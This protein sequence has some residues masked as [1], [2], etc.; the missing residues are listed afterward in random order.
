LERVIEQGADLLLTNRLAEPSDL[1]DL[2]M[3]WRVAVKQ[4]AGAS[5][6]ELIELIN[7]QTSQMLAGVTE[8]IDGQ[9]D[10]GYHEE[11]AIINRDAIIRRLAERAADTNDFVA[12]RRFIAAVSSSNEQESITAALLPKAQT[13]EQVQAIRPDEMT[14]EYSPWLKL[15]FDHADELVSGDVSAMTARAMSYAGT[16]NVEPG[17]K[18][19][20]IARV[21]STLAA[22]DEQRMRS[23]AAV[24]EPY[25]PRA[26]LYARQILPMLRA[27]GEGFDETFYLSDA[28]ILAGDPDESQRIYEDIASTGFTPIGRLT[29]FWILAQ[30]INKRQT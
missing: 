28:L 8:T 7:L 24:G 2:Q 6:D 4:H 22:Q 23:A 15:Q 21:H 14:L 30:T 12:V 27:A 11:L 19:E 16:M 17:A 3:N 29:R 20:F 26:P 25:E 9:Q 1:I 10:H 18:R 5:P 13:S